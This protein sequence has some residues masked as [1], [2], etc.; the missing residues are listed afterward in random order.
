M[1]E[2]AR[3][4]ICQ[5]HNYFIS[6]GLTLS[7]AESCTSGLIASYI[8]D[9]EGASLFFKGGVVCYW[10]ESKIDVLG[11]SPETIAS[12]GAVSSETAMEMAEK[13]RRLFGTDCSIA[14][15]GNLGPTAIEDKAVGL[16]YIAASRKGKLGYKKLILSGGRL[17]N[18]AN[19]ALE[20]LKFFIDGL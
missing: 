8:T 5:L 1:Q 12:Y 6:S 7:L 2:E 15:T 4:I 17:E 20:A 18:K 9:L 11:L 14:I 16:V 19:A 13:V 10:T 3:D